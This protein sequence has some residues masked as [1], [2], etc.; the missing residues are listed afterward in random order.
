MNDKK[1]PGNVNTLDTKEIEDA[2]RQAAL[3]SYGV[4]AIARRDITSL[5]ELAIKKE[6]SEEGLYINKKPNRTFTVNVYL[7][8]S[9]EVKITES[10][11]ECQKNIMY[12]LNNKFNQAC[13][14][15]NV[16]GEKILSPH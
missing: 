11:V 7:V 12:T 9:N 13:T 10:L 4:V 5:I 15:V 8:L 1:T 6:T 3:A 14:G 2:T 16:Y